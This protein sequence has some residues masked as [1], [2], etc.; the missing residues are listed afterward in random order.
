MISAGG[1]HIEGKHTNSDKDNG[2]FSLSWDTKDSNNTHYK[3]GGRYYHAEHGCPGPRYNL[4][5]DA[6]QK[7]D[8]GSIDF[9]MEGLTGQIGE[10]SLKSYADLKDLEDLSQTGDKSMLE[11]YKIGIKGEHTWTEESGT[12]AFR[13]GGKFERDS[14]DHTSMGSIVNTGDHQ[15]NTASLHLQYDRLIHDFTTSIGIRGDHTSDFGYSPAGNFGVSYGIKDT[16]N[17]KTNA[18]YSINI[19]SF[20]QL[21]QP[22]HGSIDQARGNPDLLEERVFSYDLAFEYK[23][24]KDLIFETALFRTETKDL[25]VYERGADLITRPQNIGKGVKQ[26][27]EFS[28]KYNQKKRFSV[29]FN[30]IWQETENQDTGKDFNYTP[31][32]KGKISLKYV[33]PFQTKIETIIRSVS[34]QYTDIENSK[35]TELSPY[36]TVDLKIIQPVRIRSLQPELY[37]HFYNL[38]DTDYE[39]HY[40]YPDDGFRFVCGMNLN[41]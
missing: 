23:H 22:S 33:F 30:Y 32:N 6:R 17:I 38:F 8:K 24:T 5:P 41:F 40:G 21:Y 39:S 3:I 2:F 27:A 15:R 1:G 36:T 12:W 18:G 10:F 20:G 37:I 35:D 19:P 14:V 31:S 25:I 11:V 9:G 7:Y 26:G 29:D 4:T 34:S 16:I 13:L 28:C